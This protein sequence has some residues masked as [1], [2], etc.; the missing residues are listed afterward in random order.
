[1]SDDSLTFAD[2]RALITAR[3]L[4][5]R[6]EIVGDYSRF[7]SLELTRGELEAWLDEV[8]RTPTNGRIKI[9]VRQRRGNLWELVDR[10]LDPGSLR[11]NGRGTRWRRDRA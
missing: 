9:R 10:L 7:H 8:A 3:G 5:S 4:D 6:V 2:V 1:V 11:F